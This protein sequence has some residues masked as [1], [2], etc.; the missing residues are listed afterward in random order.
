MEPMTDIKDKLTE[1]AA[2][3]GESASGVA[4][5]L[6]SR[7]E[8]AWDS[9]QSGTHRA[10]RE[11]SAYLRENPV[12]ALIAAAGFGLLLGLLLSRREPESF[13][14]RYIAEP[15]H[16]SKGVLLGLLMACGAMLR[17]TFSSATCAAGE[18]AENVGDDLKD[19]LKP[20]RKAARQTGRKFG[21]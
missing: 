9:V 13:K 6:K 8:D 16:Q 2:N 20:L 3:L 21:L 18:I 15:L 4:E 14:D 19:S 17:R 12:P 11:S 10:V 7:A 1:A 5:D